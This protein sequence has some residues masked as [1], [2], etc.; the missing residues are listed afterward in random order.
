[1]RVFAELKKF[2]E[3]AGPTSL[4][5]VSSDVVAASVCEAHNFKPYQQIFTDNGFDGTMLYALA[6]VS[7]EEV[8]K[9]LEIDL[10]ITQAMHRFKIL[11]KLK[12]IRT[13]Y[14]DNPGHIAGR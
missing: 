14:A 9:I 5:A 10:G 8:L 13:S 4:T 7:D 1:M 2:W 3:P 6:N 11:A 12:E